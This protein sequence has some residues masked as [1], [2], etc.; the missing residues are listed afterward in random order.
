MSLMED[1][2]PAR[3]PLPDE[4]FWTENYCFTGFDPSS[5]IGFWLHT[6]RWI[7]DPEIW[8]EVVI[9]RFPDGTV[10]AHRA[11]GNALETPDGPGGPN[12]VIK[13]LEGKRR[14][15]LQF[16]GAIRRVQAIEMAGALLTDGPI[17][18]MKMDLE[19]TSDRPI[20]DMHSVSHSQDFAG[21]GH[22]EQL[23]HARGTIEIGDERH[24]YNGLAHRDHSRG[25]RDASKLSTHHWIQ[26]LFENGIGFGIYHAILRG[27]TKPAF[28][29]AV[30][31]DGDTLY[32]ATVELPF[33]I[34]SGMQAAL[35]FDF[36]LTY[37]KGR[38]DISATQLPTTAFLSFSIP[39]EEYVGVF[40]AP[41]AQSPNMLL[42]Q[43]AFYKLA[44][45][46]AGHGMVER[47]IPGVVFQE[48]V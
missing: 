2:K 37:E 7:L 22:I 20:W 16:Y 46:T 34:T 41:S 17:H 8:R 9:I 27:E 39:N 30:I 35:P 1:D 26:G 38:L 4:K 32:D 24:D 45:G 15:A 5:G 36:S 43:S 28:A 25:P 48:T 47:S 21:T 33:L 3:K 23:G 18:R 29:K 40:P 42:E 31:W 11:Y 6:G 19:F 12:F 10:A 44:D 13:V 14:F